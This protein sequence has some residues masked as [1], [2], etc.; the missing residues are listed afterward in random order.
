[1][2]DEGVAVG[3]DRRGVEA[4]ADRFARA[5]HTLRGGERVAGAQQRLAGMHAQ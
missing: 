2:R 3:Q 1:V 5:G 4:A